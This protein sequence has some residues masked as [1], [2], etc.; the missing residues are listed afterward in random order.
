MTEPHPHYYRHILT[1]DE[2]A[3][4]NALDGI[5]RAAVILEHDDAAALVAKAM[6]RTCWLIFDAE[7]KMLGQGTFLE[8]GD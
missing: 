4:L 6:G 1:A 5:E 8:P 3:E 7:E 2:T